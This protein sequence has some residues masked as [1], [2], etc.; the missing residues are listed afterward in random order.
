VVGLS[1]ANKTEA[2]LTFVQP[3]IS[4][5]HI[6]LDSTVLKKVPVAARFALIDVGH[7]T[8]RLGFQE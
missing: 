1:S 4:R 8:D 6:A 3:T 2:T 7:G 5:T